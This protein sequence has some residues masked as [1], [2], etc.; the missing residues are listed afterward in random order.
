[1]TIIRMLL[2]CLVVQ[3]ACAGDTPPV[4]V[5]VLQFGTVNWEMDVIKHYRLDEKYHFKLDITPL[6]SKNASSVA[7]QSGAVDIILSD[8]VWVN[9][10]RFDKRM[11][12]FSP[13]SSA[14]G[15][16]YA[17]VGSPITSLQALNGHRLGIAGG[18]VDKS[19]LLF[20]AFAKKQYGFDLNSVVEPVYVAPPLLNKL[21]YEKRLALGLNFWHYSAR[22]KAKGFTPVISVEEVIKGLGIDGQVPLVGWVFSEAFQLQH[23][24]LLDSF[25]DASHD[26]RQILLNSEHEWERIRPL[27]HAEDEEVFTALRQGYRKGIGT[28]FTD[29]NF[30][31]LEALYEIMA[32]EGGDAL[33][34]GADALDLELFYFPEE[35]R[36]ELTETVVQ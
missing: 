36:N 8:W 1:M 21:M 31:S 4:R 14:A 13:T 16:L 35:V 6:G 5:A 22:L 10:Q 30:H 2:M 27:L 29:N 33:T 20:Q 34:G 26:A 15:G 9:R 25:L 12:R 32:S 7:L 23:P 28:R 24:K 11:Y 19:W 18:P 17:E 3:Q